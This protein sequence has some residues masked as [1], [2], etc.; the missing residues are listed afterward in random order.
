MRRFQRSI[1]QIGR[2]VAYLGRL[3]LTRMERLN[4]RRIEGELCSDDDIS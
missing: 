2:S 1:P 3:K 4:P